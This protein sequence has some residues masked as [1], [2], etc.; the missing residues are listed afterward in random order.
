MNL[1]FCREKNYKTIFISLSPNTEKD[2]VRLALNLMFHP[3]LWKKGQKIGK[4]EEDFRKYLG[5]KHSLSFNSG[6]SSLMAILEAINVKKGDEVLLQGFTCNSAVVPILQRK[7]KPVFVDIDNSLNLDPED[8]EKKITPKSKAVMVQHTFGCPAE[9][10]SILEIVRKNSLFLIEDCAHSLGAKYKGKFCGTFGD[11][12]FFSFGRDKIISSIFGGMAV[13]SDDNLA[14]KIEQ[15][16]EKLDYP[17]NFWIFQQLLHPV[18]IHYLVFPAYR[19]PSFGKILL[20]FFQKIKVLSKAVYRKEKKGEVSKYFPKK[21]ANAFAVLALNQFKKLERFNS[22]RREIAGLYREELERTANFVLPFSEKGSSQDKE[23]VYM[24][25]PVLIKNSDDIIKKARQKRIL[26][27][28]GWRKSPIVPLDTDIKKME[29]IPGSCKNAE[30]VAG[31]I[32]NLPTHINISQKEAEIV[33][34]FLKK[35]GTKRNKK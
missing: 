10:E 5:V 6:R 20:V 13:T 4:I 19:F 24:R 21:M 7:A 27:N 17:S 35:Y 15:F 1:C 23:N 18:L 2:D 11:A 32:L 28:D 16:K 22:H 31:T 33:V 34:D 26:L 25:Y 12:A 9:I 3:K 8:L 29:Y 14:K 30:R